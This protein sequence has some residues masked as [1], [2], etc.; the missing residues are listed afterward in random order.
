VFSFGAVSAQY[1]RM[2]MSKCPQPNIVGT[3]AAC[4]IGEVA[5]RETPADGSLPEPASLALV[6]LSLVGA[7]LARRRALKSASVD[8]PAA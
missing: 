8:T 2:N 3:F 1:L 4:A 7:G 5:F 6:S